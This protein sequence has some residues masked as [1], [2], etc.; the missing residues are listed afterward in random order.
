MGGQT[1]DRAGAQH[2]K[3]CFMRE[4]LV[5]YFAAEKWGAAIL[6]GA[7]LLFAGTAV[8]LVATRSS[9]RGM[10][11]PL[12]VLALL[13]IAVG[14]VLLARTDAQVALLLEQ[15]AIAP[16]EMA[17]AELARMA[18]VMRNFAVLLVVEVVI[19]AAGLVLAYLAG[20][21][22]FLFALGVGCVAQAGF[23]LVFDLF[24]VRRAGK[25]VE[26]LRALAP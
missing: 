6:L 11:W 4:G 10:A 14:G 9:Y 2:E 26:L 15:L 17:R 18:P 20:R 25:Y 12:G 24:A 1:A 22:D 3:R 5:A 16:P 21:S 19:L 7:G 23:M 8:A 13:E